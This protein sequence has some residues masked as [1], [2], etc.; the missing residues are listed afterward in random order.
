MYK[1]MKE[2]QSSRSLRTATLLAQ[3]VRNFFKISILA[4]LADRDQ[5]DSKQ[6][7]IDIISILAVLADRDSFRP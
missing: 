4:V 1:I 5:A 2:F 3:R 7:Q 6:S